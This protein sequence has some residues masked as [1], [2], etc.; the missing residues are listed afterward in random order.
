ML[1]REAT[2]NAERNEHP[3]NL[4][5]PAHIHDGNGFPAR[6]RQ[7]QAAQLQEYTNVRLSKESRTEE[8]LS[9]QI[10]NWVPDIATAVR[11]APPCDDQWTNLAIEEFVQQFATAEAVQSAPPK[12]G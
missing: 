11:A 12:L 10:R 7:I 8:L 5:V 2:C 6:A 3:T 9:E 4:I 1:A